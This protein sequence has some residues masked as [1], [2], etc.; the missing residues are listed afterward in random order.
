M[1]DIVKPTGIS[2]ESV[3]SRIKS[4]EDAIA[5]LQ[6]GGASLVDVADYGTGFDVTDKAA[7]VDVPFVIVNM[8]MYEDGQF[9]EFAILFLVTEDGRKCIIND[10]STGI[11]QQVK[12]MINEGVTGGVLVR[13]GL[14]RSDY[15]YVDD[16]GKETPATTFY[17]NA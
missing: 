5:A 16:K 9:G 10:G 14:S 4:F 15:K 3:L 11:R 6:A 2:D 7:L 13:K 1:S 12:T 17:L 8:R